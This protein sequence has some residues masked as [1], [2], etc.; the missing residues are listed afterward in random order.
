MK[1]MS[2]T[3]GTLSSSTANERMELMQK[4]ILDLGNTFKNY[5]EFQTSHGS[6]SSEGTQPDVVEQGEGNEQLPLIKQ[7]QNMNPPTFKGASEPIL[8]EGWIKRLE[9]MFKILKCADRQKVEL[10]TFMLEGEADDWWTGVQDGFIRREVQVTWDLFVKAFYQR[11]FSE[12]VQEKKEQ[13]FLNLKQGDLSVDEYQAQ[14]NALSRF[15]PHIVSDESKKARRF[16]KGL[17]LSI[18]NKIVPQGLKIFD[19]SLATAQLIEQDL[20]EQQQ[21]MQVTQDQR[22]KA[23]A[24]TSHQFTKKHDQKRKRDTFE[25][26]N[27]NFPTCSRCGKNHG[28]KECYWKSGAC[29]KCGKLGHMIKDCPDLKKENQQP[30]GAE[31]RRPNVHGRVYAINKP[32]AQDTPSV[33]ED[34]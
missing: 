13:E 17:K 21:E 31:N 8:A 4:A 11:Y 32:Q 33:I 14:F 16:Q 25:G 3:D 18:R 29:F 28:E 19:D 24:T 7:F 9:K 6:Q 15:A 2:G 23:K 34:K 26:N 22:G 27:Q 1:N 20:H 12:A 30:K 5:I 10:A